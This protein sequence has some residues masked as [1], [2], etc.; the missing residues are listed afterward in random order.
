MLNLEVTPAM[1][2]AHG[3]I[4]AGTWNPEVDVLP[5]GYA[6]TAIL[7][8][9]HTDVTMRLRMPSEIPFIK[10]RVNGVEGGVMYPEIAI[11]V[12]PHP[13]YAVAEKKQVKTKPE[14]QPPTSK[15]RKVDSPFWLERKATQ[16]REIRRAEID[17]TSLSSR[18]RS[19]SDIR[20][21]VLEK[22]AGALERIFSVKLDEE[23]HKK[24][25]REDAQLAEDA[26]RAQPRVSVR[27]KDKRSKNRA[28][29]NRKG[30]TKSAD[31]EAGPSGNMI[32]RS[33]IYLL[34]LVLLLIA[35][36]SRVRIPSTET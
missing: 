4:T 13:K 34:L 2:I 36:F 7:W 5:T 29:D 10:L 14:Y 19:R 26:I 17:S 6:E 18:P 35:L 3:L 28:L 15:K 21:L 25:A 30:Q 22:E 8:Q 33:L 11:T 31:A 12:E 27:S 23:R 9:N 24:Y 32:G 20:S 16:E 1:G